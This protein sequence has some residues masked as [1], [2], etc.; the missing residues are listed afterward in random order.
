MSQYRY[1]L[2]RPLL[3]TCRVCVLSCF[4]Y[5]VWG[6]RVMNGFLLSAFSRLGA[7]LCPV[8]SYK[9]ICLS[10]SYYGSIIVMWV[11]MCENTIF[12]IQLWVLSLLA[13]SCK[14]KRK[15]L[16]LSQR[17]EI[18]QLTSE[19]VFQTGISWQFGCSQ[20]T[21]FKIIVSQKEEIKH[22]GS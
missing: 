11:T 19:N 1:F 5:H 10:T 12:N 2:E 8:L 9:C 14:H 17:L 22:E 6:V 16:S 13:M 21:V 15:G 18:I 20:S 3:I 4:K 7:Y